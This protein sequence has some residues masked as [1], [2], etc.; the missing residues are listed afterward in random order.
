MNHQPTPPMRMPD[1]IP[2]RPAVARL[3]V[4]ETVYH[5]AAPNDPTCTEARFGR[6][7]E[8]D[9]QPYKRQ[10]V[11]RERWDELDLG[12]LKGKPIGQ[13]ILSNAPTNWQR[14]PTPEEKAEAEARVVEITHV[15]PDE[16]IERFAAPFARVRPGESCRF[17]PVDPGAL[18]VRCRSGETRATLTLIPGD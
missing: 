3:T 18:R 5:Q 17:E 7:I 12:W 4:V 13:L 8:S 14:W 6:V 16:A 11:V 15:E 1:S 10:I 2:P 9:E